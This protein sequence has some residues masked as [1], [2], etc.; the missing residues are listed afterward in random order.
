MGW[1]C[2]HVSGIP[3]IGTIFLAVAL[4]LIQ[5]SLLIWMLATI[6]LVLDTGGL[7][8]FV[9]TMMWHSKEV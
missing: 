6:I 5:K 9:L 8:W 2:R 3:V 4:L 7:Q 1:E